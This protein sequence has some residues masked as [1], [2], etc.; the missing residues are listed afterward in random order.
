MLAATS[1]KPLPGV[2]QSKDTS[3]VT[4][5]QGALSAPQQRVHRLKAMLMGHKPELQAVVESMSL[6]GKQQSQQAPDAV[7]SKPV[8]RQNNDP[9]QFLSQ[10]QSQ[11]EPKPPDSNMRARSTSQNPLNRLS[12]SLQDLQA[13]LTSRELLQQQPREQLG[14]D[15]QTAAQPLHSNSAMHSEGLQPATEHQLQEPQAAD[16]STNT[17]TDHEVTLA[18]S[19]LQKLA[20]VPWLRRTSVTAPVVQQPESKHI[21]GAVKL[22]NIDSAR[23]TDS[24]V[25]SG[26][27]EAASEADGGIPLDAAV[28]Q[29]ASLLRSWSDKLP[30]FSKQAPTSTTVQPVTQGSTTQVSA[31]PHASS[32]EMPAAE[33]STSLT[34]ED[35]SAAAAKPAGEAVQ[36]SS[37]TWRHL[38]SQLGLQINSAVRNT[39]GRVRALTAWLPSYPTYVHIGSHQILLPA[40]PA[41][42]QA[43]ESA[44]QPGPAEQQRQALIMHSMA[45]YR[46]RALAICRSE[47][48]STHSYGTQQGHF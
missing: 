32:P 3:A 38:A 17:E 42:T 46:G 30:I 5:T 34:A 26:A 22:R 40:S 1:S 36:R 21:G 41:L 28:Q 37:P 8:L 20:R 4:A 44:Q 7:P 12:A 18:Q 15:V 33:S 11:Q 13:K 9:D 19:S 10:Q 24:T 29:P 48:C 6:S 39:S 43:V 25:P 23:R 45:A 35:S 16:L 47:Q 2:Q 31:A 14:S 27:P